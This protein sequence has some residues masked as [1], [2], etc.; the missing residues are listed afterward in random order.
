MGDGKIRS[1]TTKESRAWHWFSTGFPAAIPG[2][3]LCV[4][5]MSNPQKILLPALKNPNP[6]PNP[7]G[8]CI[9]KRNFLG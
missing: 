7:E 9:G 3:P 6:N 4:F 1:E 8:H 2:H 5:K